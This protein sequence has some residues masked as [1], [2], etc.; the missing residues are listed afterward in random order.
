MVSGIMAETT[1]GNW[2]NGWRVGECA[3]EFK[4]ASARIITLENAEQLSPGQISSSYSLLA[5]SS[6]T[7]GLSSTLVIQGS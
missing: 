2:E 5:S 1:G 4:K 6:I 3:D 7:L